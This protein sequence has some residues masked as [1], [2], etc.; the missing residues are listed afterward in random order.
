MIRATHAYHNG[1]EQELHFCIQV[2]NK[3]MCRTKE[4]QT[5][6]WSSMI[7]SLH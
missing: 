2:E 7:S 6:E 1:D 5:K 4:Y 3:R